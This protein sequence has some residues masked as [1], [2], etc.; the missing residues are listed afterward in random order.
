[1]SENGNGKL[2]PEAVLE[3]V[4]HVTDPDLHRSIVDLGFVQDIRID[5]STV[6]LRVV[7]T[8]P[9][10]PARDQLKQEVESALLALPEI[11]TADVEMGADVRSSAGTGAGKP[12]E[13]V[14]NVIAVAS[15]KGGVGKSTIAVNLA[16]ALA[17]SGARVGLMDADITGPNVPTMTGVAAGVQAQEGMHPIERYGVKVASIGFVLEKGVPVVW[18]GPMIGSAVRQLMHDVPWGELDYLVIDLPPGTS[19]ASMSMAQDAS[20]SGAVVVSTPQEV[21]IEDA[22]KAVGMFERL[23][24]PVFGIIENMSYFTCP[25]CGE[26]TEIFGHGGAQAAAEELGLDFLGEV[27]LDSAIRQG[28]DIGAPIVATDPESTQAKALIGIAERIAARLSVLQ[29]AGSTS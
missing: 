11:T 17:R 5:N 19:D 2:T 18:R 29:Y 27:P 14:R 24:V 23:G 22:T 8:T 6:A 20:I 26:R 28:S 7:L 9:A 3:A 21:S 10:C 13:G 12:I 1:M 15:N 4:R 16:V 25:H